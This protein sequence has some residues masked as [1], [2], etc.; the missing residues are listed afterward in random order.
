MVF[1]GCENKFD[2]PDDD[3]DTKDTEVANWHP[4][5]PD[6]AYLY[7]KRVT[8]QA[9][10]LCDHDDIRELERCRNKVECIVAR[11]IAVT[12]PNLIKLQNCKKEE[13]DLFLDDDD[14]GLSPSTTTEDD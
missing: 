3:D 14:E 5:N 11:G 6:R 13:L 7:V 10:K 12:Y 9:K 8:N 2:L 1:G 4:I